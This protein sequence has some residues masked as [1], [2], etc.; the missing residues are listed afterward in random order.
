MR[1][2]LTGKRTALLAALMLAAVAC[3]GGGGNQNAQGEESPTSGGSSGG[4]ASGSETATGGSEVALPDSDRCGDTVGVD[5]KTITVTVITDLSGPISQLGGIDHGAAFKAHFEA[6]NDSGGID[7]YKVNVNVVDGKYDPVTTANKYQEARD[8]SAMIGDVLTSAGM[9]AIAQDLEADC[10]VAFMGAPNGT[11]AQKYTSVFSPSTTYGHEILNTISW[12]LNDQGE[13]DATFALAYQGDAFGQAIKDAA[14]YAA[15]EL[16][17]DLKT[18]VT[19]GPTDQDLT[20]QTQDLMSADPDYV[21]YGGLPG[22]L[23]SLS[24]GVYAKGS[25]MKFITQTGGWT[26]VILGTPAAEAIQA[27]VLVSTSYG[28]WDENKPGLAQMRDEVEKYSDAKPGQAVLTGYA[29]ALN[30]EQVIRQ[31]IKSGDLTL[32]GFYK[33]ALQVD[34]DPQGV[35]PKIKFGRFPDEPRIPSHESRVLQPDKS[36]TGGVTPLT[37]YFESDLSKGF[38]EPSS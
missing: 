35:M 18:E 1:K 8:S 16:G 11:L 5:G 9:D 38:V 17:F 20:A 6:L 10:F 26:P 21:I 27:N 31:A 33:A 4:A 15:K 13:K 23:A 7:G 2:H 24:A 34:F 37:D 30:V 36:K 28:G 32:G 22:Q 12:I 19:F 25:K 29:T 14:D 3:G